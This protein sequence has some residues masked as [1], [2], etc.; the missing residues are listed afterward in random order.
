M[1]IT[2]MDFSSKKRTLRDLKFDVP[3]NLLDLPIAYGFMYP[4]SVPS[5]VMGILG[6]ITSLIGVAQLWN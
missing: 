5:K 2:K 4:G 1:I 6:T 3:R